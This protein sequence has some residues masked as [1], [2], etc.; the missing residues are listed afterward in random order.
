[1]SAENKEIEEV[2]KIHP[3]I[4]KLLEQYPILKYRTP[5]DKSDLPCIVDTIQQALKTFIYTYGPVAVVK[6]LLLL[7][8]ITN[9]KKDPTLIIHALFNRSN[10][11][12]GLF[13][14]SYTL[15]LKSTIIIMRTI[16]QKDDG[17]EAALGG[18][19]GGYLSMFFLKDKPGFLGL[20]LL[21]RGL[22]SYLNSKLES[23][24]LKDR[25]LF[26]MYAISIAG[27]LS[28][29]LHFPYL[30]N[31]SLRKYIDKWGIQQKNDYSNVQIHREIAHIESI[32]RAIAK[33]R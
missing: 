9:L 23:E 18:F 20:F 10:L 1:M 30:V 11:R 12:I 7:R 5:F 3:L 28:F 26:G 25:L 17:K 8:N 2:P 19:I 27:M 33:P 22:D 4:Q 15:I 29:W 16:R 13:M 21:M 6:V 31:P 14:A 24:E 32:K